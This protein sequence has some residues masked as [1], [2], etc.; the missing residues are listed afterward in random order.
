MRGTHPLT[1]ATGGEAD[2]LLDHFESMPTGGVASTGPSA[3]PAASAAPA[4]PAT[5]GEADL[6]LDH[7]E[8][9]HMQGRPPQQPVI[10]I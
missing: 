3:P 6:L 1:P 9:M 4:T 5:G 2:L 7:L 10:P 8:S